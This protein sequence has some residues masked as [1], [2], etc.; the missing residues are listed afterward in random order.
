MNPANPGTSEQW[1]AVPGFSDYEASTL[2]RVRRVRGTRAGIITPRTRNC[3]GYLE[4]RLTSDGKRHPK[5][6]HGVVLSAFEG[7]RPEGHEGR[8]LDGNKLNNKLN[9]LQ[10]GT[11]QQNTA[12]KIAHGKMRG[13]R[14]PKAKLTAGCILRMRDLRC[15]GTPYASIG[16]WFGVTAT[17]AHS[18]ITGKSWQ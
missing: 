11:P 13:A 2:G 10:W 18:A 1:A 17:A 4:V 14:N 6:L 7:L 5:S 12:D 3:D 16:T 15:A 9:N 8:H